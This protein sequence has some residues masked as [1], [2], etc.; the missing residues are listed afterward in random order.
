MWDGH[1]ACPFKH[2]A[3]RLEHPAHWL[4]HPARPQARSLFHILI[5]IK[6]ASLASLRMIRVVCRGELRSPL[7]LKAENPITC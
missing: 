3:H 2:P 4:E 1:P 5:L 7:N 6:G